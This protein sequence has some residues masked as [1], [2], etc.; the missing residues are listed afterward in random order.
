MLGDSSLR[1]LG[2]AV[3]NRVV[4]VFETPILNALEYLRKRWTA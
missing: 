4:Y 2:V 1:R 3:K